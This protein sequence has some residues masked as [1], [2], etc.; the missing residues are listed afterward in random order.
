MDEDMLP[1]RVYDLDLLPE[2]T[3]DAAYKLI[4]Q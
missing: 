1:S 2:I 3:Q 4:S